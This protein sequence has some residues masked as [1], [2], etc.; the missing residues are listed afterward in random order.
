MIYIVILLLMLAGVYVY[1]YRGYRFS[2]NV[3]YWAFWVVLVVVAG[4]RYRIGTDSIVYENFYDEVPT[5]IELFN[6]KFEKF[7][8]EPGFIVLAS[9]TRSF[10]NDFMWLQFL[11][12]IIV[13]LVFFWF[14]YKYTPHR[15]LCLTLYFIILY[16][17]LNTQVMRESLAVCCFL[18]AWPSFR[19]G[20]WWFYF[21]LV[22]LAST[23]HTSALFLLLIP[24]FCLPGIRNLFIIGKRTII[25]GLGILAIGIY[26]QQN[27]S[28]VFL[29]MSV[30]ERM[31]DRV[32]VYQRNDYSTSMLNILGIIGTIIQYCL[33]PIIAIYFLQKDNNLKLE[34]LKKESLYPEKGKENV[35]AGY[36]NKNIIKEYK[37]EKRE[38]NRWE[39]MVVLGVY[40]MLLSLPMFIF[41]RYFNYF[42]IFCLAS[43]A[44][45]TF[46]RILVGKKRIRLKPSYWA[47]ILLPFFFYN[48]YAYAA[49][50]SKGGTMKYYQI[51]Y[52]YY[53]R[54]D[55]KMDTEREAIYRYLNAR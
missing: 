43:V 23:F 32:H 25:I 48:L 20:K 22:L 18:L 2:Y 15:F 46:S 49:P 35:K 42:G 21:P 33:Y 52:P 31:V 44:T 54:I 6:F 26:V 27:F 24:I 7:R 11:H 28:S 14:I 37:K 5:F 1:D 36:G 47:I 45:W 12:A 10:S 39:I 29:L 17:N 50:A 13:N 41:R 19:D 40:F 9:I 4:L 51:Y 16:L 38:F 30:T 8:F 34:L 3:A 53:T 55:P